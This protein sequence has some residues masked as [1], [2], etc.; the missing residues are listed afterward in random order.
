MA[1]D[2]GT[3]PTQN[4]TAVISGGTSGIGRAMVARLHGQGWTVHTCG[5][6]EARLRQLEYDL[7][8]V[9]GYRCD[10]ADR[11][12]VQ[13]FAS[14][15]AERSERVDLLVSNA[16]G[17]KEIDF[18]QPDLREVDLTGELRVNTEG[19]LHLVAAF[20]PGLRR[21]APSSIL[22]VSSGYAL[23]PATRAPVYSAA[24]AALHSLSKSLRRQLEPLHIGVTEVLPPLVDTPAVAHRNGAK[25]S[26]DEV[27]RLAIEGV[28]RGDAQ[29]CPG[30][31]RMLPF[32]LRL[33]PGVIEKIVAKT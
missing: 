33:V 19:A 7:P 2:A 23:A 13:K 28:L 22:I 25:L 4:R 1:S 30:Q 14:A 3:T 11:A 32:M 6:D 27:A 20:M 24:K 29:I 31:V 10:V 12:A 15:V 21:G 8:G 26:A 5:R 18:T 16:G 17:L 9:Q